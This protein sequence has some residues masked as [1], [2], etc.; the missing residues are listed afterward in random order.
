MNLRKMAMM[1]SVLSLAVVGSLGAQRPGGM[2]MNPMGGLPSFGLQNPTIGS[3]SEYE[4]TSNGKAMDMSIVALGKE[5]VDGETG[6][7]MEMRM[8]SQE[9]GGEMVMKSLIVSSATQAGVKRMIMQQ[10]GRP[11]MEMPAMMMNMMQQRQPP[12]ITKG[13]GD[14]SGMGELVGAES[15]TVPAGTYSCQHYRKQDPKG[16]VDLWVSTSITP[17][18]IVKM[19]GTDVSMVLKKALS[20]ESSHIKGEPQQ[21]QMPGGVP[22]F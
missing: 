16:T 6:F 12:P 17:W 13:G 11:P 15:V 2:G 7:W 21:M 1:M 5:N 10:P 14:K 19:T 3:G 9:M 20:N 22:H 4:V 18:G 8:I